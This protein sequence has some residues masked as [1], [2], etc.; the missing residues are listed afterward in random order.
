MWEK[1]VLY[2][3]RSSN[4]SSNSNSQ[5]NE[6][7]SEIIATE[8]NSPG[9]QSDGRRLT[10]ADFNFLRKGQPV[11]YVIEKLG[12][13]FRDVGSGFHILVY[14][15]D[16]GHATL[17]FGLKNELTR[18]VFVE[19]ETKEYFSFMTIH[20]STEI[21]EVITNFKMVLTGQKDAKEILS[22]SGLVII[23][24]FPSG[25]FGVRG[26]NVRN[27]YSLGLLPVDFI[28]PVKGEIAI[29]PA[30]L[31]MGTRKRNL[32]NLPLTTVEG[33]LFEFKNEGEPPTS[34][35]IELCAQIGIEDLLDE[36]PRVIQLND[37]EVVLT[38]SVVTNGIPLGAWAVFERIDNKYLLRAIIDLR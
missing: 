22:P 36:S 1:T 13:N 7:T 16:K 23:R 14:E 10:R 28:F 32:A 33:V 8:N 27:Y 26:K 11:S 9:S 18:V 6:E 19:G 20:D 2:I 4:S 21:Y 15:Y 38:E 3:S 34:E 5:I 25:G 24:N 17:S 29:D 30:E 31:F 35:V 37:K 12:Q